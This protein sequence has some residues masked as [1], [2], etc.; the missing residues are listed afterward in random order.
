MTLIG[1]EV[2]QNVLR[3]IIESN[4]IPVQ[5][6]TESFNEEMSVAIER[7]LDRYFERRCWFFRRLLRFLLR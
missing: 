3:V 7:S 5:S 6:T 1:K 4:N 2:N